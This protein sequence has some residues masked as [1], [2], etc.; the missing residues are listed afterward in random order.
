MVKGLA[1]RN[2]IRQAEVELLISKSHL[3]RRWLKGK[4]PSSVYNYAR[5]MIR[6]VTATGRDPENFLAWAKTV[7][8]VDVL[9][10]IDLAAQSQKSPAIRFNLTNELRSFLRSNGYNNLPK[11]TND[12]TLKEWHRGYRKNEIR[13]L[14]SFLD[15]NLH[16]LYVYM[17]VETGFRARTLL[18]IKYKHIAEDFEKRVLPVAVRLG[19]EY[20][21]RA[22]S[23]GFTFLGKRSVDLLK[24]CIEEGLVEEKPETPIINRTY[25][26]LFKV[27]RRAS[28]K[29]KIDLKI[30]I[31]HGLRKYFEDAL[32]KSG[33]DVDKKR[34]LEGHIS[35]TRAKHY[36]GRE[37]E[38][39]RPLYAKAYPHIDVDAGDP[40]LEEKIVNWQ[41]EKRQLT[42]RI[43]QL[44]EEKKN[45]NSEID[46]IK[47]EL[48]S[49]REDMEKKR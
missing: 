18:S 40:E 37:W 5:N 44:E 30:Q 1:G 33:L 41:E 27:L 19:P 47:R 16:K 3:V 11:T 46:E 32:D 43:Y 12:Y 28:R 26:N 9:D 22:K 23:A 10:L 31:N 8:P 24:K 17:I 42:E 29:A 39:L 20:Y 36:T 21:G 38:D 6:F 45:R 15:N 14:L 48:R 49:I 25:T 4:A 2:G 7:E 35:D 13:E 34:L